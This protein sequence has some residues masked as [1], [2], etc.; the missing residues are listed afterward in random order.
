MITK[1]LPRE[2]IIYQ[3]FSCT[4]AMK[5]WY[6]QDSIHNEFSYLHLHFLD[7]FLEI[8]LFCFLFSSGSPRRFWLHPEISQMWTWTV[9]NLKR[10]LDACSSSQNDASKNPKRLFFPVKFIL[11]PFSIKTEKEVELESLNHPFR[12]SFKGITVTGSPNN[13]IIVSRLADHNNLFFQKIAN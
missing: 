2:V 1:F 8:F 9:I 10:Y 13:F 5:I 11:G 6:I 7:Q 3:T 12:G 4:L